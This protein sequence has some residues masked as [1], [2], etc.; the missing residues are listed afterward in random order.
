MAPSN[1]VLTP[2]QI[3]AGVCPICQAPLT[4]VQKCKG[5]YN[6]TNKGRFFQEVFG[7]EMIYRLPR[8]PSSPTIAENPPAP[9]KCIRKACLGCCHLAARAA[10]E[11]VICK[12]PNHKLQSISPAPSGSGSVSAAI[13]PPVTP[14]RTKYAQPLSPVYTARLANAGSEIPTLSGPGSA[15]SNVQKNR[16]R[17]EAQNSIQVLY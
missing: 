14:I 7:G 4:D 5:F 3:A 12:A 6:A 17:V 16:F 10:P 13:P 1:K 8:S 9:V 15:S 2:E 11:G